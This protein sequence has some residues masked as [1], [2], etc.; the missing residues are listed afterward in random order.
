MF[1]VC[2]GKGF[3]KSKEADGGRLEL[4]DDCVSGDR[5]LVRRYDPVLASEMLFDSRH[6]DVSMPR[7]PKLK[8]K[9]PLPLVKDNSNGFG[10][11]FAGFGVR[12]RARMLHLSLTL[13]SEGA[14]EKEAKGCAKGSVSGRK[15][16]TEFWVLN[17]TRVQ[18]CTK[19][20][21]G[22]A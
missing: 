13:D 1:W 22:G 21:G 2:R 11:K 6:R 17:W 19:A 20:R 9:R 8:V 7:A 10:F 14:Q 4:H 5:L 15:L 18:R 12:L 3:F 16:S